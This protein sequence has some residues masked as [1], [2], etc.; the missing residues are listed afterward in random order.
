MKRF[1]T[2]ALGLL[3][4]AAQFA[5]AP[6]ARAA[7]VERIIAHAVQEMPANALQRRYSVCVPYDLSLPGAH[8]GSVSA[9]GEGCPDSNGMSVT[10]SMTYA[11]YGVAPGMTV[12]GTCNVAVELTGDFTNGNIDSVQVV[13]TGGPVTYT[14]NGEIFTVS[15]DSFT[16][17]YANTMDPVSASGGVTINGVYYPASVELAEYVL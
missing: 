12:D 1:A 13:M 14:L 4:V 8:G 6:N 5:F 7:D 10:A 17:V 9:S 16:V 2:L 11:A 15:F 3:L